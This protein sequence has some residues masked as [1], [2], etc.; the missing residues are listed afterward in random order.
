MKTV[1]IV[2]S[3]YIPWRGYFDLIAAADEVILYDGVQFT[4]NDWRNRNTIKTPRGVEWLSV[5]VGRGISRRIQDVELRDSAWQERHWRTLEANYGRAA[6][7]ADIAAVFEPLYRERV[8]THLSALNRTLI[9]ATC[10]ILGI[11]TQISNSW[12]YV[13]VEGRTENLVSLCAQAGAAVYSSG[14]AA[15]AYLDTQLFAE[16]GIAIKW[17]EY[18]EYPP[19]PQLWGSFVPNLS[20]L[21]LLFNCG[22]ESRWHLK[23]DRR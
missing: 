16:R 8:H 15:R 21:D 3:N 18:P 2:Q 19:Y 23:R 4:K 12:D 7:F 20:I 17:F 13:R 14:P 6:H 9:E 22:A 1:V 10:R 11:T 5:P